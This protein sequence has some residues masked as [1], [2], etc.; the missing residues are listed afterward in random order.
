MELSALPVDNAAMHNATSI[1]KKPDSAPGDVAELPTRTL[2]EAIAK[3]LCVATT[4]NRAAVT[5][6]PHIVYTRHGELYLDAVAVER[7]GRPPKEM[8][9]G[10]FKLA[11]LVGTSLTARRF[12]PFQAFDPGDARYAGVTVFAVNR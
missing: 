12:V 11:G 1:L 3:G 5:L 2:L 7:D 4:Y 8:K 9:L 6:A 10:T